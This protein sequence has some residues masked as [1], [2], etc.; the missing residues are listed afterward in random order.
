M[1]R[2]HLYMEVYVCRGPQNLLVQCG[3][4]KKNHEHKIFGLYNSKYPSPYKVRSLTHFH[5]LLDG[6]NNGLE[7][8]LKYSETMNKNF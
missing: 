6:E 2:A 5:P 8:I 7:L 1:N 3:L 4:H